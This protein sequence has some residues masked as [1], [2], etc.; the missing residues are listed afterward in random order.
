MSIFK[1][2]PFL[3]PGRLADDIYK[4]VDKKNRRNTHRAVNEER[5]TENS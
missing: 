3:Y 5:K 4:R 2:S 1:F